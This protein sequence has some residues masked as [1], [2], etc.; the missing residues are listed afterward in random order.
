MKILVCG[1]AGYIGSHVVREILRNT[2]HSVVILDKLVA[3]HGYKGHVDQNVILEAGDVRDDVFLDRVFAEHK[4]D[5]VVHMCAW[6]VVPESV[7]DPLAYY[8]NNVVGT[9]RV[10]QAM[11]KH[12][13]SKIVFSS[14]AALFGTPES[15]P[16][17][18]N[19][20]TA[21]ES[22]YGET[23]LACEWMIN[24]CETAYGI[25]GVHLRYFN[26][27]GAHEDGDIGETHD[28][29]THLIPLVLQVALGQRDHI[30]IFGTDYATSDGT[31][32]RDYVHVSDL[33]S[34]HIQ[35]LEY[36][37]SGGKSDAFN[38]GLADGFSVK[39]VVEACRK[40]TGHPI[41]A[42]EAP[43][44]EGDPPILVASGEKAKQILGWKPRYDTLE[45][46]IQTA[47]NFHQK[48]PKGYKS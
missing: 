27:C 32:V 30:K 16:I 17:L 38:L 18:P 1:G 46:I 40:V 28:P 24:A 29:E 36:L 34:A 35:A 12:G 19:A 6:L 20:R 5:A 22:P 37:N 7:R 39:E 4:P 15:T 48:H 42:V 45:K 26:A 41:P 13:C 11:K 43:R 25:R 9:L 23:K 3:T 10:L 2:K 21:P 8:D 44:R 14:T 47:W 33:G 31:C